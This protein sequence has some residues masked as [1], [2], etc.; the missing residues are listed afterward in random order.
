MNVP[1]LKGTTGIVAIRC[2]S[3][4]LVCYGTVEEQCRGMTNW[5]LW[6]S[7]PR[8]QSIS[9]ATRP[10][11]AHHRLPPTSSAESSSTTGEESTAAQSGR[12]SP[13]SSQSHEEDPRYVLATGVDSHGV[14]PIASSGALLGCTAPHAFVNRLLRTQE[15]PVRPVHQN[16]RSRSPS[17]SSSDRPVSDRPVSDRPTSSTARPVSA[18]PRP[19]HSLSP[20]RGCST[21]RPPLPSAVSVGES[22]ATLL[23]ARSSKAAADSVDE[24][25]PVPGALVEDEQPSETTED[26]SPDRPAASPLT[27]HVP[28]LDLSSRASWKEESENR[29]KAA[30]TDPERAQ[31]L[32]HAVSPECSWASVAAEMIASAQMAAEASSRD[33]DGTWTSAGDGEEDTEEAAAPTTGMVLMTRDAT[34]GPLFP[35]LECNMQPLWRTADAAAPLLAT[36]HQAAAAFV[37]IDTP[38]HRVVIAAGRGPSTSSSSNTEHADA[39]TDAAHT[40]AATHSYAASA[41]H[42]RAAG[43]RLGVI[44]GKAPPLEDLQHPPR[45]RSTRRSTSHSAEPRPPPATIAVPPAEV[46]DDI[47]SAIGDAPKRKPVLPRP[48]S[49]ACA[50]AASSASTSANAAARPSSAHTWRSEPKPWCTS[51]LPPTPTVA[52]VS[53]PTEHE[54]V[55]ASPLHLEAPMERLETPVAELERLEIP[56]G[57]VSRQ[58]R[59]RSRSS[60]TPRETRADP[61]LGRLPQAEAE[62]VEPRQ[63]PPAS[64]ST[65]AYLPPP[66]RP[67]MLQLEMDGEANDGGDYAGFTGRAL[68]GS[69]ASHVGGGV[70]ESAGE[71]ERCVAGEGALPL[72]IAEEDS[73]YRDYTRC[74]GGFPGSPIGHALRSP[75]VAVLTAYLRCPRRYLDEHPELLRSTLDVGWPTVSRRRHHHRAKSAPYHHLHDPT[76]L[77]T[78][79]PDRRKR[80]ARKK[81]PLRPAN[82]CAEEDAEEPVAPVAPL[83]LRN[84]IANMPMTLV[85]EANTSES[86]PKQPMPAGSSLHGQRRGTEASRRNAEAGTASRLFAQQAPSGSL[87]NRRVTVPS[88]AERELYSPLARLP[89]S[90]E[91]EAVVY[92]TGVGS[93]A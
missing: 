89:V 84:I 48:S 79:L 30:E 71:L 17:T 75:R 13:P 28:P 9:N 56:T 20:H 8:K 59:P 34:A 1:T 31:M 21:A 93:H 87:T 57:Y 41:P 27:V 85:E 88:A 66:A 76:E 72:E 49:A 5:W 45:P 53:K 38:L 70:V 25:L 26:G 22:S 36:D 52:N 67:V 69:R 35:S 78:L 3:R 43:G 18:Q 90:T 6:C 74:V 39:R 55:D 65:A 33:P 77:Q 81:E 23:V 86:T 47:T 61:K 91:W 4:D 32:M 46:N 42:P 80:D 44:R 15:K 51:G 10:S 14:L 2:D 58:A 12:G 92:G 37:H 83:W 73:E 62:R 24:L 7:S 63:Q 40:N 54:V 29:S 60:P 68:R 11:S 19:R 16:R 64:F 50:A 82:S